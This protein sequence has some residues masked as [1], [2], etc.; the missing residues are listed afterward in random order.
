M[1]GGGRE[2]STPISFMGARTQEESQERGVGRRHWKGEMPKSPRIRVLG[3]ERQD[4]E[5]KR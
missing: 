3:E 1:E 5:E 4:G 2:R